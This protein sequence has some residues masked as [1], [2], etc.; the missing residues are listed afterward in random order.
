MQAR[1]V[2]SEYY[3]VVWDERSPGRIAT[4]FAGGY[5]NHAGSRGTLAGPAGIRSNYD[6]LI[7]AFPDVSFKLDDLITDRDKVVARYTMTGTHSGPFQSI[8]P[9]GRVVTVPG[10][11]IYRVADSLI[12]ES[13]VVRDSLLLLKQIG[14]A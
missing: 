9:T 8:A 4:F 10:I 11:G 13:W 6:S 14:A 7:S 2:V 5:V 1:D 3:R 12:Q